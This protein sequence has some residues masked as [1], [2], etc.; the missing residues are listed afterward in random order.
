MLQMTYPDGETL[1][2]AYDNGGL[3]DA[4]WGEKRGNRYNYL[5][6]LT[7]DEF[8][9]RKNI[10]YGN[11]VKSSYS[12]DEK[13][14]RLDKLITQTPD[15]R[16]VQNLAYDYDLVGNVMEIGNEI[17]VPTNT[18]LP[19]G[20]VTQKF[21]YDDLPAVEATGTLL[22]IYLLTHFS[23][24]VHLPHAT[25]SKTRHCRASSARYCARD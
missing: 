12:Y 8:G 3:L 9:Q 21:G 13:T 20:P 14:R 22:S 16:I 2:Y 15:G 7:Y 23:S 4:A 6:S 1:Y 18:A 24:V 17:S 11:G 5:N 19:A 25:L 10:A